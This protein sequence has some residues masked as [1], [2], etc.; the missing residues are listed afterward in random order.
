MPPLLLPLMNTHFS[1][2]LVYVH[3][4]REINR[5]IPDTLDIYAL[6]N[7]LP[8]AVCPSFGT[9]VVPSHGGSASQFV[10]FDTDF[11]I[12]FPVQRVQESPFLKYPQL[13]TL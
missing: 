6:Q 4:L 3:Y 10:A 5:R 8:Q 12:L 13:H 2:R 7:D 1:I 11:F 9:L